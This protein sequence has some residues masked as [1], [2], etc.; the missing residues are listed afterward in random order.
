[1]VDFQSR[2]TSR[3]DGNDEGTEDSDEEDTEESETVEESAGD[4]EP[5]TTEAAEPTDGESED[6]T[7]D[8]GSETLPYAVITVA[9]GR[10]IEEDATGEVIVDAIEHVGDGVSTRELIGPDYDSIQ[11]TVSALA[12]RK[13]V[14]AIIT[15]GG[16]GV[17]PDDETVDAVEPLF[18]KEL[19]GFGELYRVLS[20]DFD[21]TAVIRTRTTAGIVDGVPVFC[22]PD[23]TAGA[24]RG[25]EQIVLEEA[26]TL[27]EQASRE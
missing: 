4:E 8:F 26:E 20:H 18:D 13:D 17:S 1:M 11:S 9:N 16:T 24:R 7:T 3:G 6:E 22:L 14:E 10:T 2:D 19:P 25:V 5:T 21:G 27:S 23:D 15:V 12:R